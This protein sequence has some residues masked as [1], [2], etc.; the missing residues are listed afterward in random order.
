MLA[1]KSLQMQSQVKEHI[2]LVSYYFSHIHILVY[3]GTVL[4][5]RIIDINV[6]IINYYSAI[7]A[8]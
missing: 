7:I 2:I 4:T 8:F 5:G 3:V 1:H 6:A